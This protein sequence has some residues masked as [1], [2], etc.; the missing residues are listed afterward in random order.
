M[1]SINC[2]PKWRKIWRKKQR[3]RFMKEL[4]VLNGTIRK[5]EFQVW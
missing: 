5:V 4:I 1:N 3:C 2:G